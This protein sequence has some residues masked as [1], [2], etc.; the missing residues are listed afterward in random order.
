MRG[1]F[2]AALVAILG[3]PVVSHAAVALVFL[4]LGSSRGVT[5]LLA[6]IAPT[7]ILLTGS[8][9]AP[10]AADG[11]F[12]TSFATKLVML[13]YL[14]TFPALVFAALVLRWSR[15][16]NHAL[17][18]IIGSTLL[19]VLVIYWLVPAAVTEITNA[20]RAA[21]E[22][23]IAAWESGGVPPELQSGEVGVA[24]LRATLD[25]LT[26]RNTLGAMALACLTSAIPGL[27]MARWWQA[28]LYNPGGFQ[29][30]FHGLRMGL[31]MALAC[32]AATFYCYWA[33][34]DYLIWSALFITPPC[35]VGLGLMHW[36]F[37][38]RGLGGHWL[39]VFYAVLIFVAPVRTLLA[40]LAI[41][42]SF[43]NLRGRFTPKS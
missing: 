9:I 36:L 25:L 7:V 5:V 13:V 8:A 27:L 12:G 26:N 23:V 42:D 22:Q 15:S 20:W 17:A 31:P 2:Q 35:L 3:I 11:L 34:N 30:E 21:I 28:M 29:Q 4:R 16:W 19:A 10:N 40:L 6:A 39:V 18:A 41:L 14:A 33:G 1:R 32:M 38:A 43:L 24:E 37:K